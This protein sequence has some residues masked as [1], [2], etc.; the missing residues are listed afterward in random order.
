MTAESK[1]AVFSANLQYYMDLFSINRYDLSEALNVRY[2]TLSE[3]V[4][5]KKYPR[6]D[7]IELLADY[8]HI[9]IADLIE[10]HAEQKSARLVRLSYIFNDMTENGQ[11]E[12]LRY[13]E[14][15]YPENKKSDTV[16]DIAE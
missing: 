12:L 14:Y 11:R 4:T 5:G 9:T 8:F 1:K 16:S 7:K 15:I 10:P 6:I 2:S 13:A 3:W